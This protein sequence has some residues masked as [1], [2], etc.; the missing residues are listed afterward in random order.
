MQHTC[1]VAWLNMLRSGR[2]GRVVYAGYIDPKYVQT[3]KYKPCSDVYSMGVVVMQV[4]TGQQ[5]PTIKQVAG[6]LRSE[7][8]SG[9]FCVSLCYAPILFS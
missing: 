7:S 6:W 9:C 4:L 2:H 3:G 1:Y 8:L 5:N